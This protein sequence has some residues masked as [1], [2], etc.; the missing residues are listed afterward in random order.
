M[1]VARKIDITDTAYDKEAATNKG[2]KVIYLAGM[3]NAEDKKITVEY[4]NEKLAYFYNNGGP[5]MEL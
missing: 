4:L 2:T 1:N 5:I 3:K